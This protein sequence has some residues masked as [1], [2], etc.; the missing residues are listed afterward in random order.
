MTD[1]PRDA[2]QDILD[3]IDYPYAYGVLGYET[4]EGLVDAFTRQLDSEARTALDRVRALHQPVEYRGH[5]ICV[6]CSGWGG[7]STDNTP[8]LHP[9]PTIRALDTDGSQP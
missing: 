6:H 2:R 5:A 8:E 1:Q 7:D 3:A 9:C 4:R